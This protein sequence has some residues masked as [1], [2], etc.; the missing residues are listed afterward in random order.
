MLAIHKVEGSDNLLLMIKG[1]PEKVMD[2]CS[3]VYLNS[4][5]VPMDT[6]RR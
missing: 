6:K 1:A 3:S 4:T 2:M 5:D